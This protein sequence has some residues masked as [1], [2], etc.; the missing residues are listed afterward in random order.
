MAE[1]FF[2]N[3]FQI[4]EKVNSIFSTPEIHQ[5]SDRG[6][7]SDTYF[8]EKVTFRI[9]K[10]NPMNILGKSDFYLFGHEK[11]CFVRE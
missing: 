10:S 6:I 1:L 8:V 2:Y 3:F 4:L 7:H 9:E 11:V 5:I